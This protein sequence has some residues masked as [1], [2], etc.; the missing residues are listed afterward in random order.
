M[1]R[2]SATA[3]ILLAVAASAGERPAGPPALQKSANL[4]VPVA[5]EAL[6]EQYAA[7]S[8]MPGVEVKYSNY[9]SV[10]SVSGDTGVV[11]PASVRKLE[12]GD[13]AP[14]VLD[15]FRTV[16]LATSTET[17]TVRRS[18]SS[19]QGRDIRFDQSIRGIPVVNGLVALTMNEETG[20]VRYF[21]GWFL[22]DRNLPTKA[23]L[24]AKQAWQAMVRAFEAS[25][26]AK[27]GTVQENAKPALAYFGVG[28]EADRPQLVWQVEITF[29]CPTGRQDY[30][31]VWIDAIDGAIAGRRST[32]S[33][34]TSPGPCQAEEL[35]QADCESEPHPLLGDAPY[36]SSCS[37]SSVRPRLI[38][39]RIGCTNSFRLIWPRIPGASQYH[40]ISAPTELGWAF[41][42]TVAAGQI[43][44]CTTD[45]DAP[46]LVRMRPCDGCGCGEWSETLLMDPQAVCE[47]ADP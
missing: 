40:V 3:L 11:L 20:R 36:S 38:A 17:L 9:G 14:A 46:T 42:H 23:E 43:H 47:T 10:W 12:V 35:E 2:L 44:Q 45:V 13:S 7:L 31:L 16:L 15:A 25:G 30:E 19:S 18:H 6:Q 37:G 41:T 1:R 5:A 4:S 22:P 39:T 27:P 21:G 29:T 32:I 8:A 28:P 33:Y 34:I 26:D 24:S